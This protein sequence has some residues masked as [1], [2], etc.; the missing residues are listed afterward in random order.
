MLIGGCSGSSSCGLKIFRIQILLKSSSTLIKKII[1]PRGIFIPTYNSAEINEEI[2]S[3][4]T[5]YFFLYLFVF[6]LLTLILA[7]DG[8]DFLTA[9][10]GAAAALANVGPGLSETIGPAGNYSGLTE[11]SKFFLSIGMLI[12]RLEL[13]PILIIF[14]PELWKR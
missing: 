7:F 3:S 1:Q 14:S 10:S 11:F 12:G 13:F 2:L 5:G 4:V 8:Q 6:G 9:I